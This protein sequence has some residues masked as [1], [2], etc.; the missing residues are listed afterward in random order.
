MVIDIQATECTIKY[1]KPKR[2]GGSPITGY[3][4]EG[5]EK[6]SFRWQ[7]KGVTSELQHRITNL[8]E[9]TQIQFR[10]TAGNAAGL[11]EPSDPCDPVTIR[12]RFNN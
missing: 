10:V 3:F 9:G 4:I 6:W 11:G 5:K 2:D 12:P 8:Q 7:K 1:E